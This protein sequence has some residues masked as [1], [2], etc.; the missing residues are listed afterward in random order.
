LRLKWS[1]R[2][3]ATKTMFHGDDARPNTMVQEGAKGKDKKGP[4]LQNG[5]AARGKGSHSDTASTLRGNKSNRFDV[6]KGKGKEEKRGRSASGTEGAKKLKSRRAHLPRQ[7]LALSY[8]KKRVEEPKETNH[9]ARG[10]KGE[11]IVRRV[12]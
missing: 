3:E 11:D 12:L 8:A 1:R 6:L 5:E 10:K 7:Q 9:W 2:T 4:T